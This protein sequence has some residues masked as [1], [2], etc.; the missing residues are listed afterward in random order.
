MR[1]IPQNN[2]HV[3][4]NPLDLI[5]EILA[6]GIWRLKKKEA[7]RRCAVRPKKSSIPPENCLEVSGHRS[8]VGAVEPLE[9]GDGK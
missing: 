8:P 9:K 7:A 5:A 6:E 2:V 3:A 4:P 1:K